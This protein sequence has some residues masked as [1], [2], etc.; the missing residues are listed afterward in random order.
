MKEKVVNYLFVPKVLWVL[1]F[2][3]ATCIALVFQKF[4]LPL[5]PSLHAGDGLLTSDS[6]Y[7]HTVAIELAD[8]IRESGW[9][10]WSLWPTQGCSANVAV[11]SIL[12]VFFSP[13]PSLAIPI[14]AVLHASSGILIYLIA[15]AIYPGRVGRYAGLIGSVLFIV[16]PSGLNWYAQ[17]HKDG[18]AILGL[19]LV[20][21]SWLR[22]VTAE[23][24]IR[25]FLMFLTGNILGGLLLLSVRPYAVDILFLAVLVLF[26]ITLLSALLNKRW[27]SIRIIEGISAVL[28]IGLIVMVIHTYNLGDTYLPSNFNN[29]NNIKNE[30]PTA[31][32]WQ[33][34]SSEFT[35]SK[36]DNYAKAI[37]KVRLS[38]ICSGYESNS[39]IDKHEAPENIGN[40]ILYLPRVLQ[41]ALFAPFPETWLQ[42]VSIT[43][44]I[45]WVEIFIWYLLIPGVLFLLWRYCTLPVWLVLSFS[46][47]FLLVYGYVTANLGTLHRVRYPFIMILMLLGVFGWCKLILKRFHLNEFSKEIKS[48]YLA[49]HQDL[50]SGCCKLIN[51]G[52][53]VVCFTAL[54]FLLFFYRD[55]LMGQK[56][57]VGGEL[58][59]FFLAMLLP[60]FLVNVFSIPLGS[61]LVP[62][63]HKIYE[64]SASDA[65]SMLSRVLFFSLAGLIVVGGVLLTFDKIIYSVF[66]GE[67]DMSTIFRTLDLLPFSVLILVLSVVVVIGNAV[68]NARQIYSLPA[69]FHITV[70]VCAIILLLVFGQELGIASVAIGM[71]VGQIINLI[72]VLYLLYQDG[73]KL[74]PR[75]VPSSRNLD[76]GELWQLFIAL[77]VASLFMNAA[78]VIDNFMASNLGVGNIGVYS[79]GNKVSVFMTGIIGAAITSVVLPRFSSLL[80]LGKVDICRQDLAFLIYMGTAIALPIGLIMFGFCD[81]IVRIVFSGEMMTMDGATEV[82][83]VAIFGVIQLPFFISHALLIRFSNANQNGKLIVI[84]AV[85]GLIIN[86]VLNVIL[87][88]AI[89]V[90]G[91]AL[92]TTLSTLVTSFIILIMTMRLSHLRALDVLLIMMTWGLY[93]TAVLCAYF[94]SYVG[95]FV[96]I[97][98]IVILFWEIWLI[99]RDSSSTDVFE[100]SKQSFA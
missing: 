37:T 89:G 28:S 30:C 98:A 7:F 5:V 36:V 80:S 68:L 12:Y 41:I 40:L 70:P 18:Y 100:L 19:L 44:I 26:L 65:E 42:N 79:L 1:Y 63:Y 32:S 46:L 62:V 97:I 24:C 58:D 69:F 53:S 49:S 96:S 9:S 88:R 87:M 6:I 91:L 59:A 82:G 35:P 72:L 75:L 60:M 76:Y 43:K 45:G 86:V 17:I 56:F 23:L 13:D 34:Q 57:G 2:C 94:Q 95:V 67:L 51:S 20:L 21:Y 8:R 92:A 29:I 78:L 4:L 54:S 61:A 64:N 90:A 31:E 38:F 14:N 39:I 99:L 47:V 48:S 77:A 33:W 85:I 84:A 50:E 15:L 3:Y 66:V 11:L 73:F 22:W 52:I 25:K 16:F 55:V 27:Q 81:D 71:V 83:R 10:N 93:L 74:R